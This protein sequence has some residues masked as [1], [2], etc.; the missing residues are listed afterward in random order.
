MEGFGGEHNPAEISDDRREENRQRG[1]T[2][3]NRSN[4]ILSFNPISFVKTPTRIVSL[5]Q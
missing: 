2:I 5:L 4:E 1:Q 3:G